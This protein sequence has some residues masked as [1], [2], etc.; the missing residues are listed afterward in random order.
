MEP[1]RASGNWHLSNHLNFS[2]FTKAFFDQI[3]RVADHI[4]TLH[5][6]DEEDV[7]PARQA[8]SH[9]IMQAIFD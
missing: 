2:G 1:S 3:F 8:A 6:F 5:F 9:E 7:L 4:P